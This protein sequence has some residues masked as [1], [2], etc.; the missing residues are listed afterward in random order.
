MERLSVTYLIFL[1]M[2]VL[3]A[4]TTPED[5]DYF[6]PPD[7]EGGWRSL[8]DSAQIRDVAGID[9][10]R[11]DQAFSYTQRTSRY[12]GLLVVR[13][14]W[15][16]YE[17]Y[18]GA[19]HRD[20]TPNMFSCAKAFTSIAT[21]ILLDEYNNLFPDGLDQ[22]VFTEELLPEAFPLD[23]A[24][25]ADIRL[26]HLL[27]MS[28]GM[29]ESTNNPGFVYGTHQP[30]PEMPSRDN[31][32]GPDLNALRAPMWTEPGG[33]YHYSSQAVH[34]LSIL[35]SHVTGMEL[36]DYID[37]KIA[38]PLHFGGW[39]YTAPPGSHTPGGY[40]IGIRATD[41]LRFVYLL[42]KNGRWESQQLVP[43]EYIAL[44]SQPSPYNPHAPYSLQFEVNEDGH[45]TGAPRDAY[46]KSGAG[47][48]CIYVVPSLDMVIYKMASVAWPGMDPS[49]YDMGFAEGSSSLVYDGA[50]D[51][52]SFESR[53][54]FHDG[55]IDGDAGTRRVLE[56]VV[57]SV[58]DS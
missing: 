50:R 29:Q 12:G 21:G 43:A 55:P 15:L 13:H 24:R 10:Q 6:P 46:F 44:A 48:F 11:L 57:A 8:S 4:C 9:V 3:S 53:D 58:V 20:V 37:Q 38:Q 22:K 51:D 23:D 7:S 16:V 39:G 34:V 31:A 49:D 17:K 36:Q 25:K 45:V 56:M 41:V 14:G 30:L 32:L 28:S 47:G 1:A 19:A 33:G 26:G 35:A 52:W 5:L 54:Q 2:L 40:G 42:L 18:F 27:T